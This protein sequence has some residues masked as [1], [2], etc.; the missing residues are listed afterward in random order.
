M[1]TRKSQVTDDTRLTADT[2]EYTFE[3]EGEFELD[4]SL[5]SA[6]NSQLLHI[7]LI[8]RTSFLGFWSGCDEFAMKSYLLAT[9]VVLLVRFT[10]LE[11]FK[12]G[13]FKVVFPLQA[14]LSQKACL[15][16]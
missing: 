4:S 16:A 11:A 15:V 13:E 2:E 7:S 14:R 9:C 5:S 3:F 6:L 8:A 1:V 12:E 10:F